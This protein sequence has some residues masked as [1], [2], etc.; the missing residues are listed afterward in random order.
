MANNNKVDQN[1]N[2]QTNVPV[3]GQQEM[4]QQPAEGNVVFVVPQNQM[5]GQPQQ[6]Q[7][8]SWLKKHWKVLLAG[9]G[10]VATAVGSG[11][12]AY[13]KGK[14]A[15]AAMQMQQPVP[16]DDNSLNPNL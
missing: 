9:A 8:E 13:N 4:Q 14:N 7:K 2:N 10:A 3:E 15:G 12:V 1:V 5:P 6:E 11:F 16:Y